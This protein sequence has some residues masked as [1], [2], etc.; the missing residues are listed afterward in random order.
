MSHGGYG[1][2]ITE[3]KLGKLCD[4]SESVKALGGLSEIMYS[5]LFL[6]LGKLFN[7]LFLW[8]SF[9]TSW[10]YSGDSTRYY[11]EV[12]GTVLLHMGIAQD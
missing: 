12:G 7:T 3:T 2:G 10:G 6:T 11:M 9:P 1:F 4:F 5:F 8:F